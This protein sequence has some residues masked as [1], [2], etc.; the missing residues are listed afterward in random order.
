MLVPSETHVY[1]SFI[2]STRSKGPKIEPCGTPDST[3]RGL[4]DIS[5]ITTFCV[6]SRRYS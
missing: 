3:G 1:I 2:N 4:D 6:L 5:P